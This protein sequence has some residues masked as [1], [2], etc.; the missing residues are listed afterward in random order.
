[1]QVEGESVEAQK[2][3]LPQKVADVSAEEREEHE[4][5]GHAVYRSWCSHCIASKGTGNPHLQQNEQSEQPELFIDY[6][7]RGA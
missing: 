7:Y 2:P 5:Q 3:K 4:I 6:G 1:M